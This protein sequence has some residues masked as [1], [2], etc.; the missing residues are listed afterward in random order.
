MLKYMLINNFQSSRVLEAER[1]FIKA[2]RLAPDDPNVHHRY[3]KLYFMNN[4]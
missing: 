4:K 2:T 3:G 1:W